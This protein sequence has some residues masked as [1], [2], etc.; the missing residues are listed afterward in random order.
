MENIPTGT[1]MIN[2]WIQFEY[3]MAISCYL[4]NKSILTEIIDAQ[5][6]LQ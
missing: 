6:Q 1:I 4:K 5:N 3:Q 2:F